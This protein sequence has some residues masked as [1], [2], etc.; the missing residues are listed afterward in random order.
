MAVTR[1]SGDAERLQMTHKLLCNFRQAF[2]A[3]AGL[4]LCCLANNVQIEVKARVIACHCCT[5]WYAKD[6]LMLQAE[7]RA[8][9]QTPSKVSGEF[10]P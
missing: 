8:A 6:I 5:M 4:L 1:H 10:G 3:G 7:C 9:D 2:S